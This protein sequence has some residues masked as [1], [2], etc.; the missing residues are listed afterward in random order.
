MYHQKNSHPKSNHSK[1]NG[2]SLKNNLTYTFF[3]ISLFLSTLAPG[4][5]PLIPSMTLQ[6]TPTNSSNLL[7]QERTLTVYAQEPEQPM[8]DLVDEI[9]QNAQLSSRDFDIRIADVPS[10]MVYIEGNRRILLY[11]PGFLIGIRDVSTYNW[12]KIAHLGHALGH[13][14][15]NHQLGIGLSRVQ[16]EL[17]A[18]RFN[19]NLMGRLGA[20][21][22]EVLEALEHYHAGNPAL[23]PPKID[24]LRA[25]EGSWEQS[26]ITKSGPLTKRKSSPLPATVAPLAEGPGPGTDYKDVSFPFPPPKASASQILPERFFEE[27]IQLGDV[28]Q[29]L[30]DAIG[31]CGYH[32]KSYYYVPDGFALVTKLEQINIDAT[33]KMPPDRW[34]PN[35][36]PLERFS[37]SDYLRALFMG[38]KGHFRVFVFIVTPYPFSQRPEAPTK[39][40]AQNWLVSGF[41]IL[42]KPLAEL[43]FNSDY[44]VTTLIYQFELVENGESRFVE[45]SRHSCQTHL[46]RSNI[47]QHL[48]R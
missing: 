45:Q 23:Y 44:S 11:H 33:P 47:F 16:E 18:D 38:K 21:I 10:I 13:L 22:N 46:E 4:Q 32:E 39:A 1:P 34:S 37:L 25:L 19:G 8:R 20:G 15:Y 43:P 29:I 42:P 30:S 36:L 3:V 27:A 24:R 7:G 2:H 12:R 17:A 28:D 31:F 14:Y 5:Q 6:L 40:I 26:Q 9:L 35:L 41:N 48:A